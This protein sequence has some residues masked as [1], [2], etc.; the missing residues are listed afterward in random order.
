MVE[1]LAICLLHLLESMCG[2]EWSDRHIT[3]INLQ[4]KSAMSSRKLGFDFS[5]SRFAILLRTGLFPRQC[6]NCVLSS[7]ARSPNESHGDQI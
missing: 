7:L 1:N 6:Y 3:T 5:F 2:V 4:F